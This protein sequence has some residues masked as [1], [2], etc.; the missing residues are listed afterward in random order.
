MSKVS[1]LKQRK[2]YSLK[3]MASKRREP[4]NLTKAAPR[5]TVNSCMRILKDEARERASKKK[6]E[7]LKA[8]G[9]KVED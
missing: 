9:K 1:A 5:N 7:A 3:V 4:G 6:L 8:E 2:A